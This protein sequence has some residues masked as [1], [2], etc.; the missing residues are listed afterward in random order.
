MPEIARFYGLVI[1][2]FFMQS[3]HN[4]PHFYVL[5]GEEMGAFDLNTLDILEGDLPPRAINLVHEW[6]SQYKTELLEM[7]NAREVSAL[8]P[9]E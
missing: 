1:K 5:Y 6:A 9:L 7:W 8:L 4:Q 2:M 3:E